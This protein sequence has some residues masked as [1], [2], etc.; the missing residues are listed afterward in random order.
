MKKHV[1]LYGLGL[2]FAF[3]SQSCSSPSAKSTAPLATEAAADNARILVF[4]KTS[5][6]YHESI[7]DGI[8]AI[9]KLGAEH[10]V[11]VDTTKNSA[12]FHPDSLARYKAVVFL[13]TTQDVLNPTQQTAFE[14]YIK[15][16]GGYAGIHAA[17]DTEYDWPWYNKLVGAYFLSHPK[18]QQATVRVQNKDHVST[19]HL[20][21]EWVYFDEWYNYKDINPEVNVLATLD[22]TTY[23]GGKNGDNH[24]IVWYHAFDGGRAFYTGL[25]HTKES[26]TNP[27]FVKHL[28]GGITYAM[29]QQ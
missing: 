9:Q 6:Y 21:D 28:W 18:Q 22:E 1:L 10:Q 29:G 7:S 27:L 8:A 14:Q 23:E 26:Y 12:Y 24:P 4:S 19:S 17:A 25:G 5:G 20:P 16:G 13:S 2:L 15:G 3:G 11:Q